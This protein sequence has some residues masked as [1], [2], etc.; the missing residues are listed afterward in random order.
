MNVCDFRVLNARYHWEFY[1]QFK[2]STAYG[3]S[4]DFVH[5]FDVDFELFLKQWR[6]TCTTVLV[7]FNQRTQFLAYLESIL[8]KDM[9]R[10]RWVMI[11]SG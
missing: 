3:F 7:N 11:D 5:N 8:S 2:L 4:T 1:Q 6:S 9:T 10:A